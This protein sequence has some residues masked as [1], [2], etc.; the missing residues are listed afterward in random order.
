MRRLSSSEVWNM[1]NGYFYTWYSLTFFFFFCYGLRLTFTLLPPFPLFCLSV[2]LSFLPVCL[3]VC[4]SV[5]VSV[6][7]FVCLRVCVRV[8]FVSFSLCP[9]VLCVAVCR[10]IASP[11]NPS[12]PHVFC[13]HAMDDM[14][15]FATIGFPCRRCV[16]NPFAAKVVQGATNIQTPY[17]TYWQSEQVNGYSGMSSTVRWCPRLVF[18]LHSGCRNWDSRCWCCRTKQCE[19]LLKFCWFC[20]GGVVL[21]SFFS[22]KKHNNR[23][24]RGVNLKLWFISALLVVY[25]SFHALSTAVTDLTACVFFGVIKMMCPKEKRVPSSQTPVSAADELSWLARSLLRS[26]HAFMCI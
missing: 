26:T 4:L 8:L 6:H 13:C 16:M 21:N 19:L 14:A 23:R 3:C 15:G 5:C 1:D 10:S 2:S 9:Y 11:V 22:W 18:R 25:V 20:R 17:G 24:R 12:C 7:R